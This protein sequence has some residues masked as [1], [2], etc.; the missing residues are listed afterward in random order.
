MNPADYL[1]QT[2]ADVT[3]WFK[4][5]VATLHDSGSTSTPANMANPVQL[6]W[7]KPCTVCYSLRY[8]WLNGTLFVDGDLGEA[9]YRWSDQIHLGFL[10]QCDLDYF[11]GKLCASEKG[12]HYW[13]FDE[14]VARQ[15]LRN[16]LDVTGEGTP[17]RHLLQDAVADTWHDP[18]EDLTRRALELYDKTGDAELAS[19][20]AEAGQVH[21]H[22]L[23][24]HW[25]G[26]RLAHAQLTGKPA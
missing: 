12:R 19:E 25:L 24:A 13:G 21:D 23:V 3:P 22:R 20:V 17:H 14:A 16:L 7:Q 9:V 15:R 4:D 18:K 11:H 6:L 1:R 10:A 26:L 2:I 8:L 5:H